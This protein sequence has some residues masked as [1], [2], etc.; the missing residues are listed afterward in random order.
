MLKLD[1]HPWK[2]N[3]SWQ[4]SF[5]LVASMLAFNMVLPTIFM[6]LVTCKV[7]L[8][9]LFSV[10]NI[11]AFVIAF[12]IKKKYY[13]EDKISDL[14]GIRM[15]NLEDIKSI[16]LTWGFVLL[17]LIPAMLVWKFC[18]VYFNIPHAEQQD[19]M[20]LIKDASYFE[21]SILFFLVSIVA[22]LSEEIFI[23]RFLY[24]AVEELAGMKIAILFTAIAFAIAHFYLLGLPGLLILG[25]ALQFL[26][27]STSNLASPILFHCFLNTT[28]LLATRFLDVQ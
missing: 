21:L 5:M 18:L 26:Y 13:K 14:L 2:S 9:F 22:P 28:S 1:N 11:L 6:K 10:P 27:L 16:F 19:L 7:L 17:S 20:A 23:R 24:G 15:V 25:F 3:V 12:F 4:I 8:Y